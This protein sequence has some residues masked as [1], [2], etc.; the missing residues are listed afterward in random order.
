MATK[1]PEYKRYTLAEYTAYLR[2]YVGRV[3]FSEVHVHATWKP[4]IAQFRKDGG[5]KLVDA[6]ARFH[7]STRGWS[8]MA[9]HA[10]IDPDGYVW[11]GRDLLTPPVSATNYNDSDDDRIH[12]FMFEMIGNFDKGAEKLEGAQLRTSLGICRAII[13]MWALPIDKVRFHR[14]MT[15]A[16]TCPGSGVDK[17]EFIAGIKAYKT[18]VVKAPEREI[19]SVIV[20]GKKIADGYVENGVTYVPVRSVAEALG[21]SVAW[22]GGVTST[23]TVASNTK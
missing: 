21:A 8:D 10:T 9:Q 17:A 16:K 3:K 6:M 19:V 4:T 23:V 12:P 11:S 14:D 15:N 2:S 5:L 13:D 18:E 1:R 7:M 22:D 20:N